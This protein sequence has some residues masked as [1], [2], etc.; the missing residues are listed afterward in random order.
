MG[1][2]NAFPTW[3]PDATRVGYVRRDS[4][5]TDILVVPALG[6]PERRI[7]HYAGKGIFHRAV[8]DGH[9]IAATVSEGG[10]GSLQLV[11]LET[12]YSTA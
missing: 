2:A 12:G 5:G 6:G 9:G 8:P 1:K 11:S 7:A 4:D 3:S 10:A